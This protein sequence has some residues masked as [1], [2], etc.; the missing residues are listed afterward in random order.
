MEPPRLE[1]VRSHCVDVTA[2]LEPLSLD[3]GT[4]RVRRRD[5]D[6]GLPDRCLR[7]PRR[8]NG[9]P[10]E[11]GHLLREALATG[12]VPTVAA[13]PPDRADRADG[14]QL[15]LRQP[16]RADDTDLR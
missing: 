2:V 7:R 1:T 13:N 6:V 16:S 12:F 11:G 3:D 10:E 4:R 8:V 15:A 9:H 5:G 14:L